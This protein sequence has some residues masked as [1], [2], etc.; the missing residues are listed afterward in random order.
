MAVFLREGFFLRPASLPAVPP[1]AHEELEAKGVDLEARLEADA[2]VAVVHLVLVAVRAE[3]AEVARDGEE[4]VIVPR[5]KPRQLVFEQLGHFLRPRA[6]VG[7][8]GLHAFRQDLGRE[9]P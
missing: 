6:F 2:E 8:L 9:I 1:I 7:D 3:Q 4:K 5:R